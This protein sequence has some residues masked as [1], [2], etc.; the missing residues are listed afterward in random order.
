MTFL[1]YAAFIL[2][3]FYP[4]TCTKFST[5]V[6]HVKATQCDEATEATC[7]RNRLDTDLPDAI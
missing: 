3:L 5:A 6:S 7:R 1:S 2:C 4:P